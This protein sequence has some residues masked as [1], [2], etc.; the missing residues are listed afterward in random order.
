MVRLIDVIRYEQTPSAVVSLTNYSSLTCIAYKLS[1]TNPLIVNCMG[2]GELF[3][4]PAIEQPSLTWYMNYTNQANLTDLDLNTYAR[5]LIY[6]TDYADVVL[7]DYGSVKRRILYFRV[8]GGSGVYH[9]LL[10]SADGVNWTPLLETT[11]TTA[12]SYVFIAEF[13]YVKIQAKQTANNLA[14]NLYE[15]TAFD[16]TNCLLYKNISVKDKNVIEELTEDVYYIFV[17]P[18]PT[19]SFSAFKRVVPTTLKGVIIQ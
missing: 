18:T 11:V 8:E 15:L 16:T 2:K 3:V 12:T 17:N 10:A 6:N 1:Q 4:N 7:A 9:L 5:G 14:S 19:L 13:R